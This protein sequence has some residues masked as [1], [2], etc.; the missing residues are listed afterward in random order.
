MEGTSENFIYC[1]TLELNVYAVWLYPSIYV[2][3]LKVN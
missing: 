2:S 1:C 3:I